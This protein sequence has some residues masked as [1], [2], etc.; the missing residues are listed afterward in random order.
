MMFNKNLMFWCLT[1]LTIFLGKRTFVLCFMIYVTTQ[2]SHVH[3]SSWKLGKIYNQR[4]LETYFK[5]KNQEILFFDLFVLL[6]TITFRKLTF[7]FKPIFQLNMVKTMG[8]LWCSLPF[9]LQ[10]K[11][12]THNLQVDRFTWHILKFL[13]TTHCILWVLMMF[14]HEPLQDMIPTKYWELTTQAWQWTT[15]GCS[16]WWWWDICFWNSHGRVEGKRC[17]LKTL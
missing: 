12:H 11:K 16:W 17:Y 5:I 2:R 13:S 6:S 3:P 1:P 7:V 4:W 14:F 9:T 8:G 10:M 15:L